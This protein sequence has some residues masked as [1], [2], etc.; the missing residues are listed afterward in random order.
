MKR[1]RP[2]TIAVAG[3]V[4]LLLALSFYVYVRAEKAIDRANEMRFQTFRQADQLRHSSD[5]L[6]RM[7]RTYIVTGDPAYKQAFQDILDIR[8]GRKRPPEGYSQIYWDLVLLG[9][10]PPSFETAPSAP[11]METI[12][13]TGVTA[14]ELAKLSEAKAYSD[15]LTAREFAAMRL[16]ETGGPDAEANRARAILMVHDAVYHQAKAA[17]MR[18]INEFYDMVDRRTLA[19]VRDAETKAVAFRVVFIVAMV[20]A[21]WLLWR[22]RCEL[23]TILGG[24]AEEVHARITQIGRGDFSDPQPSRTVAANSVLGSLAEMRGRL[25]EI[26]AARQAAADELSQKNEA[27]ARSNAELESFAYVAS[28]DLRE[29]LRNVTAF[30]ALLAR[31]LEGRL[32]DEERGLLKILIDAAN[33]MDSLVRD[34]LEVARVGR[35]D[36]EFEATALAPVVTTALDALRIQIEAT[37]A[38]IIV[39]TDLPTVMGNGDE[40][41]RVFMNLIGN[42]LKYRGDVSPVVEL[43]AA[44]D[45]AEGWRFQIRDNGIGI[46]N[47]QGYEE[48]IFGLFQRLHQR[49]EHGGGTGIGLPICRKIINRHGGRIWAE[50]D[51]LGLGTT[52]TFTLPRL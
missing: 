5:D 4:L 46:E 14:P 17:I 16:V 7:V 2:H 35:S 27:L 28:H 22:A 26:E 37:G 20:A 15:G 32:D 21:V 33:R 49:D 10:P 18:P 52:I 38:R 34:L 23:R 19:A 8:E 1:E 44:D 48:R 13:L 41:Y 47:G 29:P 25:C 31:R 51:G 30:S 24:A 43:A 50:S 3:G 39:P 12:R 40:L 6:T 42:A 45:E 11:L 36:Q 9:G